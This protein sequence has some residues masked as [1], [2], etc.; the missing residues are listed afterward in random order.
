MKKCIQNSFS[1]LKNTSYEQLTLNVFEK[2][3][4]KLPFP[5]AHGLYFLLDII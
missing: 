3:D 4:K 2:I 5:A 1:F